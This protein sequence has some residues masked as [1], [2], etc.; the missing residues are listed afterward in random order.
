MGQRLPQ[1]RTWEGTESAW[2]EALLLSGSRPGCSL[3]CS[4]ALGLGGRR[5]IRWLSPRQERAE[6]GSLLGSCMDSAGCRGTARSSLLHASHEA[7]HSSGLPTVQ[8]PAPR[9]PRHEFMK[10]WRWA[11]DKIVSVENVQ[12]RVSLVTCRWDQ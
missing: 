10:T 7:P 5:G 6:Q 4:E 9:S 3:A 2:A 1:V 12:R 8:G 11:P